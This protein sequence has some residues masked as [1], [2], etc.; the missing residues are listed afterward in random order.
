MLRNVYK[1]QRRALLTTLILTLFVALLAACGGQSSTVPNDKALLDRT[2]QHLRE[3]KSAHF[4]LTITGEAYLDSSRTLQLR[5][6]NGDIVP[7]DQMQAKIK[8]GLGAANIDVS[9]VTLGN[10]KY[11]TNPVTGQWGPIQPGFDYSPTVL[12][13]KDHGLSAVLGQLQEVQRVGEEQVE[14]Q[15]TYHLK[16]KVAKAAIDP[17]TGGVV[18]GDPVGVDLWLA[19]DS[20]NL[21]RLVLT[22]GKTAKAQPAV[23]T[24][25]LTNYDQPVTIT[26]PQ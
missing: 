13:D 20:A 24:L 1:Q 26:K 18:E 25:L 11:Q 8:I 2:A 4:A 7:P 6:A 9:L 12:F 5:A 17:I 10:E 14:G 16:G 21:V 19:K 3:V 22:E 23:W 15:A